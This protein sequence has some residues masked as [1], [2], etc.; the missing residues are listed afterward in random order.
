M[1]RIGM[2]GFYRVYEMLF[3]NPYLSF[4]VGIPYFALGKHFAEIW[5][6]AKG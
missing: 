6:D 3:G 2:D 5:D 1:K 4:L